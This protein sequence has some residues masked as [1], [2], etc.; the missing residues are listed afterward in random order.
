MVLL[1]FDAMP[2]V[3]RESGTFRIFKDV[4]LELFT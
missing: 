4:E 3:S 1:L 2:L